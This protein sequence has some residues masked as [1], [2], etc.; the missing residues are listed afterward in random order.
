MYAPAARIAVPW[1]LLHGESDPAVDVASA[2]KLAGAALK[3][4][5]V[6]L[7]PGAGH[8]FGAVHPFAGLTQDLAQAIDETVKWLGR[9]L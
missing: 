8:T 3:P 2:G 4:P 7:F 9:Y 6:M 5:R 1:L